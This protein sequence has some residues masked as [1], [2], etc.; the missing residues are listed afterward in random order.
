MFNGGLVMILVLGGGGGGLCTLTYFKYIYFALESAVV[1]T[2]TINL[3][4]HR[5]LDLKNNLS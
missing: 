1:E 3:F 5:Q 4:T 2:K